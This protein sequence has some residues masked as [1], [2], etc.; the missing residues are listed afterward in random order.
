M[1]KKKSKQGELRES[2]Q[3]IWLAGLGALATAEQEGGKLFKTLVVKGEKHQKTLKKPVDR[4]A[5]KVR[6]TV[7]DVRGRAGKTIKKVEDVFDH[8]VTSALHR[9]G[10]PTRKEIADLTRRVETLTRRLE[11]TAGV[12]RKA[13]PRKK[14]AK[15]TT[16]KKKVT[17]RKAS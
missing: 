8:Q 11:G 4:A 1:A 13:A 14:V 16:A 6:G 2:A 12:K 7:K 10:V 15:K 17:R 9:L 5:K 3:K